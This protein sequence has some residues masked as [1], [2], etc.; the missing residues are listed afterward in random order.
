MK[1]TSS[2]M[3]LCDSLCYGLRLLLRSQ[4]LVVFIALPQN[5]YFTADLPVDNQGMGWW[6]YV[7]IFQRLQ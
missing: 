1:Q 6:D 7:F 2:A 4:S 5:I 3:L